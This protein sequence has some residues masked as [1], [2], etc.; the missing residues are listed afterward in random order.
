MANKSGPK[1]WEL[2]P[3]ILELI[4]EQA[5]QGLKQADIAYNVG[6]SEGSWYEKKKKHPEINEAI[7]KAKARD[8]RK[9]AGI[10]YQMWNDPTHPKQFSALIF[11]LKTQHG[12]SDNS[13]QA[14]VKVLPQNIQ[15]NKVTQIDKETDDGVQD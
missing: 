14:D 6:L 8:H 3:E 12:W 2:T 1:G 7:K 10:L 4:A 5:G 11:Y 13:S 9:A 15:F